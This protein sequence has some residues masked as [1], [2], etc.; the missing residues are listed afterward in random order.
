[1]RAPLQGIP[2]FILGRRKVWPSVVCLVLLTRIVT[3][4]PASSA[5]QDGSA[6]AS[7]ALCIFQDA[8]GTPSCPDRSAAD[9]EAPVADAGPDQSA[10]AGAIVILSGT[11]SDPDGYIAGYTWEQTGGTTVSLAGADSPTAMFTAPDVPADERLTFQL[12]V[13]DSAGAQASD[14]MRV[15]VRGANWPPFV[16][17]FFLTTGGDMTEEIDRDSVS[18]GELVVLR[19]SAVDWDGFIVSYRWEQEGGTAVQLTDADASSATFMAPDVPV[20][21]TLTFWL[22]VDD[23]DGAAALAAVS[24][25]V[26]A[27]PPSPGTISGI[28][29]VGEGSALDEDTRDVS[30]ALLE[31]ASL[32]GQRLPPSLPIAVAGHANHFDD[33]VDVYRVTL[34]A[35]AEIILKTGEWPEADLDLYLADTA[36]AIVDAAIGYEQVEFLGTGRDAVGEFLVMVHAVAGASNYVLTIRAHDGSTVGENYGSGMQLGGEF[37]PDQIVAAYRE[38]LDDARRDELAASIAGDASDIIAGDIQLVE[39]VGGPSGL[40]L[41][42]YRDTSA[43]GDTPAALEFLRGESAVGPLHYATPQAARK[44]RML[45]TIRTLGFNPDVSYA[46]PNY[47]YRGFKSHGHATVVP[48]DPEYA[49]QDHY[50]Q[51]NLPEAWSVTTGGDDIVIAVIDSGIAFHP[52]LSQRRLRRR[53]FLNRPGALGGYDFVRDLGRAQDGDGIDP[54]PTE[55]AGS[56]TEYHGTHVAGTIGAETNNGEGVAGVTWQGKIM[57]LRVLGSD[58]KADSYDIIQAI[59]YAA[60]LANRYGLFPARRAHIINMSLG[61][62]NPE[63]KPLRPVDIELRKA[64]RKAIANGVHVVVAAGNDDCDVPEPKSLIDGVI[65]V[66]A[67]DSWDRKASFSNFGSTIDVAAP[68]VWVLSTTVDD[69]SP[70]VPVPTFEYSSGTSMAAP[71][72]SGVLALMLSINPNLNPWLVNELIAG[73]LV[74]PRLRGRTLGPITEDL[75]PPGWDHIYGH[76]LIDAYRAVRVVQNLLSLGTKPRGQPILSV[77]PKS[78]D[79]GEDKTQLSLELSNSGTGG[80]L[81]IDSVTTDVPWLLATYHER[82]RRLLT[83]RVDRTG[84]PS[85]SYSA[86]ISIG[87]NGGSRTVPVSMEMKDPGG[88]VGTVY[89]ILAEPGNLEPVAQFTTDAAQG[90]AYLTTEVAGGSYLVIAGTDRD[91]DGLICDAGEACGVWPA[92]TRGAPCT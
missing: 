8:L 45:Q 46:G 38:G 73:T 7:D 12:T 48:N 13:S 9:N 34:S 19:G 67:V 31:N 54:D 33:A 50:R 82:P 52:D 75:G 49:E 86:G 4:L 88:D 27:I 77:S 69:S 78:L 53:R 30:D 91:D 72:V 16:D 66:S 74:H 87:S 47:I 70:T 57:L 10:D 76:G 3:G 41:L 26:T 14:E 11:A 79:F 5:D 56:E 81:D 71:H 42:E 43:Q 22:T 29:I 84:L 6:T 63:C 18:P 37:E 15:T 2:W 55:P 60:G 40:I 58:G 25:P 24:V 17:G 39:E 65:T 20:D 92:T 32:Q 89:V 36:G 83:V 61:V 59:H 1:M 80:P 44:A 21:E 28:L 64:I 23:D 62:S 68:G 90:Y 51:I 85:G 35:A